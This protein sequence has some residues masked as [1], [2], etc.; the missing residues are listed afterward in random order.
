MKRY[1]LQTQVSP[2]ER[3]L[4]QAQASRDGLSISDFIRRCINSYLLDVD[5]DGPLIEEKDRRANHASA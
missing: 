1:L 4:V 5:D 2:S 3:D